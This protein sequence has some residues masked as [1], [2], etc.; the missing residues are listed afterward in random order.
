MLLN[1]AT[2]PWVMVADAGGR[3]REVSLAAALAGADRWECLAGEPPVAAAV[4]RLLTAVL[5]DATGGPRDHD[6]WARWWHDG[7]PL[8]LISGYLHEQ[9]ERMH[10]HSGSA[11]FLQDPGLADRVGVKSVGELAPHLPTGQNPVIYSDTTDLGGPNPARFTQAQALRWLVSFHQ[12]SRTGM[13]ANAAGSGPT[14]GRAGVLLDRLLA[15]PTAPTLARTLLLNTPTGPVSGRPPWRAGAPVHGRPPRDLIEL[16]T[17]QTRHVRLLPDDDGMVTR[18]LVA[19]DPGIDPVVPRGVIAALDPHITAVEADGATEGWALLGYDPNVASW[20]A[21]TALGTATRGARMVRALEER[22]ETIGRT[23]VRI[24]A[25]GL[26]VE[27]KAKYVSW[28]RESVPVSVHGTAHLR[29]AVRIAET[30]ADACS[31]ALV[32]VRQEAGLQAPRAMRE[33]RARAVAA[34]QRSYW[35]RLERPGTDLSEELERAADE[36][37]RSRLVDGWLRRAASAAHSALDS[38][39]A[40]LPAAPRYAA[41]RATGHRAITRTTAAL[42]G[43]V[44]P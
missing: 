5:L 21:T 22:A 40:S 29:N 4:L 23:P 43:E 3:V 2:D 14:P 44:R 17:W 6:D 20:R 32:T 34:A 38:C 25:V 41:A 10:L 8:D 7:L 30:M 15:I 36:D 19:V 33:Q 26:A 12:F 13:W 1:A 9:Q 27:S 31:S 24:E 18:L 35:T 16:L 11:P 39:T 28:M 42:A 37:I